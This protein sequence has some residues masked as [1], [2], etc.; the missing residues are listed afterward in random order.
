MSAA[1]PV[2]LSNRL[3]A[4]AILSAVVYVILSDSEESR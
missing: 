1:T 4:C 2:I 3:L